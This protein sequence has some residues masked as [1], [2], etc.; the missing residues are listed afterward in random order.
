MSPTTWAI[1]TD[2]ST[3]EISLELFPRDD[4]NP[5]DYAHVVFRCDAFWGFNDKD[6]WEWLGKES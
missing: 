2:Q 4:E 6:L 5:P 1:K 3:K